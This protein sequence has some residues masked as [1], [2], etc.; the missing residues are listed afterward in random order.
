MFPFGKILS[1]LR[2]NL[3]NRTFLKN[4]RQLKVNQYRS[5]PWQQEQQLQKLNQ[6][7]THAYQNIPYYHDLFNQIG[8]AKE[9]QIQLESIEAFQAIP[10]LTKTSIRREKERM[11]ATDMASRNPYQNSSG[12]STGE[13]V[14]FMQDAQ[15]AMSNRI[16]THL[17]YSWR[18]YEPYDD[19]VIIWGAERDIFEGKKSL[20]E[21]LFDIYYNRLVL[22]S[23]SMSEADMEQYIQILNRKRPK[24]IKGYVQSMYELANY[25]NK[26]RIKVRPQQAIHLAAGTL[27]E[28]MRT[29]IEKIFGTQTYNYYGS[30]EV[31]S[32]ASECK[33]QDGLHIMME[34][35]LVEVINEAGQPCQPGEQGEIVVTTL[36][37]YS[38]P[39]I[40]Y[41]IGDVGILKKYERCSCGCTYP[42]LEKVVGR[43]TDIFRTAS[44]RSI[45]GEYF[46]HLFYF[47]EGIA[48]FQVIQTQLDE[49]VI[50]IVKEGS[51]AAE[52]LADIE[53]KIKLVMGESC[54]VIFE[55]VDE[56]EKTQTG[57]FRYTISE[58]E[59]D[60][61]KKNN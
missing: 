40:R 38:M 46:T 26:H 23:F 21:K 18:G 36:S 55:Y 45:D 20:K 15:Y 43:T 24:L 31:G 33:A 30:R 7:L 22:N 1:Y 12:G 50:K 29:L 8:L 41:R 59:A 4:Y 37:N 17:A 53:Y 16:H 51:I 49:I 25:A 34:H 58:I 32:I 3:K 9:N 14:T 56:I 28:P 5:L 57:K 13:P 27:Y 2:L 44:G 35:T 60:S 19:M 6:L 47:V 39:L 61:V 10:F 42:K 54:R 48:S 11:H 52:H